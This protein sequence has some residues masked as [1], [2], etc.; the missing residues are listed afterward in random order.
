MT[1]KHNY[2]ALGLKDIYAILPPEYRALYVQTRKDMAN[3]RLKNDAAIIKIWTTAAEDISKE[4][5]KLDKGSLRA[6]HLRGVQ[7]DILKELNSSY[8]DLM[9]TDLGAAI[10]LQYDFNSDIL[11]SHARHAQIS[12]IGPAG[13]SAMAS[14][15]AKE[16]TEAF[17]LRKI[18]GVSLSSRIWNNN[19]RVMGHIIRATTA[20]HVNAITLARSLEKYMIHGSNSLTV[21]ESKTLMEAFSGRLPKDLKYDAFR[22]ARTEITNAFAEGTYSAGAKNPFYLGINWALSGRHDPKLK[23]VCPGLVGFHPKGEEPPIPH[24]NCLCTQLPEVKNSSA[25]VDDLIGWVNNPGTNQH[26]EDW[27][28]NTYLPYGI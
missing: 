3:L 6:E 26:L 20:G 19:Q 8:R 4:L 11:A 1:R 12:K 13:L 18:N 7:L 14:G 28:Q 2:A 25:A 9:H 21:G 22:L 17:L 5:R 24:P 15:L 16:T 27:Y 23:C 10:R